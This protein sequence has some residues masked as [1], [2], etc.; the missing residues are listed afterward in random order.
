MSEYSITIKVGGDGS[1]SNSSEEKTES[2]KLAQGDSGGAAIKDLKK[3]VAA[4]G[5]VAVGMKI[6]NHRTSRVFVE[7]GN[8]QLQDNINAT[9]QIAGQVLALVGGFVAGGAIGGLAV[10]LGIATDYALQ[11]SDY[12]YE[13]R[14]DN[15]ILSIKR[16]RMGV[17][18]MSINRSRS[19][20]Q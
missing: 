1:K 17:G 9:K 3:A 20:T 18:G 16:E 10:G 4:T 8:R 13:R 14:L 19:L 11:Y 15:A 12:Q 5:V 7:T 6:I 2:G